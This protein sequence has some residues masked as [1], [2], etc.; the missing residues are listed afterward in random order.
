MSALLFDIV[1][2]WVLS[3]ATEDKRK[4]IRWTLSTVLEDLDYA[5]DIAFYLILFMKSRKRNDN[6]NRLSQQVG[7]QVNPIKTEVLPVNVLAP[8]PIKI[9]Q[10]NLKTTQQ[11]TYLRSTVCSDGEGGGGEGLTWTSGR[12]LLVRLEGPCGGAEK[13]TGERRLRSTKLV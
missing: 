5:D 2:D 8:L 1:I 12:G 10:L 9:G 7:L 13:T 6:L 4:G 3:R 11:F